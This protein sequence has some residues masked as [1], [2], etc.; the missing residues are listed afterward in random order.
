M[1][2]LFRTLLER[3]FPGLR[4]R[5]RGRRASPPPTRRLEFDVLT[6]RILPGGGLLETYIATRPFDSPPALRADAAPPA[7]TPAPTRVLDTTSP[8]DATPVSPV[9]G[10]TDPEAPPDAGP[11]TRPDAAADP[12][13]AP[14]E[15]RAATSDNPLDGDPMRDNALADALPRVGSPSDGGGGGGAA[16]NRATGEGISAEAAA[17][18]GSL[19][20]APVSEPPAAPSPSGHEAQTW[21]TLLTGTSPAGVVNTVLASP[22]AA[23]PVPAAAA[24]AVPADT[25]PVKV[26]N[27]APASAAVVA[28]SPAAAVAVAP[29]AV[30]GHST[31]A[32][33][34]PPAAHSSNG[35]PGSGAGGSGGLVGIDPSIVTVEGASYMGPVAEFTDPDGDTRSTDYTFVIDWGDGTAPSTLGGINYSNGAFVVSGQHTAVEDGSYTVTTTIQDLVDGSTVTVTSPDTVTD[36]VLSGTATSFTATL[37]QPFTGVVAHIGDADPNGVVGDYSALIDWGDGST[38]SAGSFAV[39]G[40][41]FQ[42]SGSHTYTAVGT[43][44]T[45]ITIRDAGGASITLGGTATVAAATAGLT[46]TE[47]ADFSGPVAFFPGDSSQT[48]P[49]SATINWG[50]GASS[51]G[52]VNGS[53]ADGFTVLGEHT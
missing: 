53:S 44:S 40:G 3:L 28:A 12:A 51:A 21:N 49:T 10:R 20:G 14:V 30:P 13:P 9:A 29:T 6:A 7:V 37:G 34:S 50:D 31:P 43:Y 33:G 38:P 1:K 17:G 4:R 52:S 45:Q 27:A 23:V 26:A 18:A 2:R 15:S 39:S 24:P 41:T 16:G 11:V 19:P 48:L 22:V 8:A 36:A 42:V 46:A 32:R 47:G 5:R 25:T 35:K